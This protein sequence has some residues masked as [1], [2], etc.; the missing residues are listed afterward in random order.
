MVLLTANYNHS[1]QQQGSQQ[2]SQHQPTHQLKPLN[3]IFM[4]QKVYS[5]PIISIT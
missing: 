4:Q 1:Y 2:M 5:M 3:K